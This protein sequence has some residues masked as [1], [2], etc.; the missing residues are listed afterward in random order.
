MPNRA[1]FHNATSSRNGA[2][3]RA[4]PL[5]SRCGLRTPFRMN[6]ASPSATKPSATGEAGTV[7]HPVPRPGKRRSW[8]SDSAASDEA[9]TRRARVN[10]ARRRTCR[11]WAGAPFARP[12]RRAVRYLEAVLR[13]CGGVAVFRDRCVVDLGRGGVAPSPYLSAA[14]LF[15]AGDGGSADRPGICGSRSVA[16]LL[17]GRERC[18]D[19]RNRP[20]DRSAVSGRVS[21]S[22]ERDLDRS[23][24]ARFRV[25]TR[26]GVVSWATPP[27]PGA[28]QELAKSRWRTIAR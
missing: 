1:G 16:P 19:V 11:A 24:G 6:A 12:G 3:A 4:G 22:R 27:T 2:L 8:A 9:S 15:A 28:L 23:R 5:H 7:R 14:D 17:R 10:I 18:R 25:S 20:E 26:T 21:R 13:R